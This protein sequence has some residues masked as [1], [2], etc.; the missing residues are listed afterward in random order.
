MPVSVSDYLNP[1]DV[2]DLASRFRAAGPTRFFVIDNFLKTDFA[3]EAGAAFPSFEEG[4][5]LGRQFRWVNEDVKVQVTDS[6]RF[7]EPIALLNDVLASPELL[8]TISKITGMAGLLAD[9]ELAGGGMH[10]M[11]RKGH[12]DVHVDFNLLQDRGLHRRFNI[13]VYLTEDW[14]EAWDGSFE[15]WDPD[16]KERLAE[17][18]P[19]FNRCVVFNTTEQSFHG[20]RRIRCP[21]GVT[22]KPFASYYYT[23]EPP[24]G[25]DG[26]SHDTTYRPRPQ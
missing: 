14:D 25:R 1:I 11:G 16:V 17:F 23:S 9:P 21:A 19:L 5:Q 18:L 7:A 26:E 8:D 4:R 12:L 3:R 22:R 15:L 10:I 13:I 20:V 6:A 24:Q 2:E